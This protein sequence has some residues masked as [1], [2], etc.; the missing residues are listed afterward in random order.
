[1]VLWSV[2]L[3]EFCCADS[4]RNVEAPKLKC[5]REVARLATDS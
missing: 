1:M 4:R 3:V 2:D 5:G